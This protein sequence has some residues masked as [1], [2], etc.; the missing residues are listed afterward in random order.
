MIE[1]RLTQEIDEETKEDLQKK[2]KKVNWAISEMDRYK[3][4]LE[5]PE[6]HFTLEI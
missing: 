3:K 5:K 2:L 1:T 6:P 4:E